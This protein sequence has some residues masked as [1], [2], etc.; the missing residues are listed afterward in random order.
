MHEKEALLLG[1]EVEENGTQGMGS[2]PS[3]KYTTMNAPASKT[4]KRR[5]A[6][7][8]FLAVV[9]LASLIL[10]SSVRGF[11]HHH[12][13][14]LSSDIDR[15]GYPAV[16]SDWA[17]S[18]LSL[19]RRAHK[20]GMVEMAR[21]QSASATTTS[22]SATGTGTVLVDFEVHQPVLTPDGATLDSGVSNGEAGEVEDSCQV[23][24]MDYVFAY[25]YGEP[26]IGE[27]V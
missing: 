25:S 8:A 11:C 5:S 3:I 7:A 1:S 14:Q 27:S 18:E 20:A 21:R 17:P 2:G 6:M 23:L 12:A 10:L 13:S 19:P 9:T 4:I 24:L 22:A 15:S 16:P 26:Y